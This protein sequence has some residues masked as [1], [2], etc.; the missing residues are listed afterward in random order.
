MKFLLVLEIA[1]SAIIVA[2]VI[3]LTQ[4]T[5][6]AVPSCNAYRRRRWVGTPN[7]SFAPSS[8]A[9]NSLRR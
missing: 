4:P 9:L 5:A 7:A 1:I 6:S 8:I 2:A 3:A